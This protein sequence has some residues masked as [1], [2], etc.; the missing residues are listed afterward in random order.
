MIEFI[1]L[2]IQSL[3]N[4]T[5]NLNELNDLEAG[6]YQHQ[7]FQNHY[8]IKFYNLN[9]NKNT[10]KYLWLLS[11]L[12]HQNSSHTAS[13]SE[14][15]NCYKKQLNLFSTDKSIILDSCSFNEKYWQN[16]KKRR[17][18]FSVKSAKHAEERFVVYSFAAISLCISTQITLLADKKYPETKY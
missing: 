13:S 10:I 6:G 16:L 4:S 15:F 12:C 7:N 11:A 8:A 18:I 2:I 5:Q 14:P 3:M 1:F 9:L 17:G